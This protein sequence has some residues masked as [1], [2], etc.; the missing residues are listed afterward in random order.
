M[1]SGLLIFF[2]LL[3]FS[4][5]IGFTSRPLC[6]W[7]KIIHRAPYRDNQPTWLIFG[8]A[9]RE[10][11][12]GWTFADPSDREACVKDTNTYRGNPCVMPSSGK[13]CLTGVIINTKCIRIFTCDVCIDKHVKM[14]YLWIS[15]FISDIKATDIVGIFVVPAV[16]SHLFC[17]MF[18]LMNLF[19]C[20]SNFTAVI[21]K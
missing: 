14:L 20:S 5:D 15:M 18:V 4:W 19:H 12:N 11:S 13:P 1:L 16:V 7:S 8:V 2:G 21:W 9:L 10:W 17:V 3:R 6:M